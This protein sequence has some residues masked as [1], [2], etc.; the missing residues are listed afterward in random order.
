M[1]ESQNGHPNLLGPSFMG[2][3]M[4]CNKKF[5]EAFKKVFLKVSRV[6]MIF[7]VS[8]IVMLSNMSVTIATL[9]KTKRTIR[10]LVRLFSSMGPNVNL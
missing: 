4:P 1:I 10:T 9:R 2:S 6:S 3:P 8:R 7:L 5:G